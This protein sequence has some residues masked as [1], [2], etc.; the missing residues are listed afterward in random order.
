MSWGPKKDPSPGPSGP[1]VVRAA[2]RWLGRVGDQNDLDSLFYA[3]CARTILE[4]RIIDPPF[5]SCKTLTSPD[6][7]WDC[8]PWPVDF[9]WA[10]GESL[11]ACHFLATILRDTDWL[12]QL[13]L[14]WQAAP[15]IVSDGWRKHSRGQIGLALGPS[16]PGR[17]R[18]SDEDIDWLA[19][20]GIMRL[21]DGQDQAWVA[22]TRDDLHG[23][24]AA[25]THYGETIAA[26]M[27]AWDDLSE[28]ETSPLFSMPTQTLQLELRALRILSEDWKPDRR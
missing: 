28:E 26:Q 13:D 24:E 17:V 14:A 21:G 2:H 1:A 11:R 5:D 22:L 7:A 20:D 15:E 8:M 16:H 12:L 9:I 27:R 23:A 10:R 18:W 6:R 4:R 19:E 3:A 25:I